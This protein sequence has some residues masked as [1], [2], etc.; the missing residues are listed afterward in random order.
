MKKL[1]KNEFIS[2]AIIAHI[3]C[4]Y[5]YS[6]VKYVNTDTKVKIICLKHGIFEQTPHNHMNGQNCKKC[7]YEIVTSKQKY[8]TSKFINKAKEIH[9]DKYDYSLVDFINSRIKVKIICKK[10]NYIFEQTPSNHIQGAGC[11]RCKSSYGEAKVEL[12]LLKNEIKYEPQ[13]KFDECKCKQSLPFDFY[14][15]EF[16]ILIEYNGKL[17]YFKPSEYFG[18]EKSFIRTQTNDKIKKKFC[19][20]NKIP[21]LIIPYTIKNIELFLEKYLTKI[22]SHVEHLQL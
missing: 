9:G 13:K 4:A 14:L 1:T 3:N 17:H 11:R 15:P 6:L 20:Q 2:K 22:K 19:K 16:K 10:H 18:G 21:L 7:G 12:F 8:D 5:D